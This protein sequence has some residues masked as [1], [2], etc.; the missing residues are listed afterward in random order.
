[1]AFTNTDLT[2]MFG[3]IGVV[4]SWPL[5]GTITPGTPSHTGFAPSIGIGP[6]TAFAG[7]V[8]GWLTAN[9]T[10]PI[11]NMTPTIRAERRMPNTTDLLCVCTNLM[12]YTL[13]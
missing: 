8:T 6:L 9:G 12:D 5:N 1:M 3:C 10:C 13:L 2:E 4:I 11:V 7:M